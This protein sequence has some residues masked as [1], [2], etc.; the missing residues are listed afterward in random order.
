MYSVGQFTA[1][2][3]SQRHQCS[4]LSLSSQV[5]IKGCFV[6]RSA[7]HRKGQ[8]WGSEGLICFPCSVAEDSDPS[9]VRGLPKVTTLLI[10][11]LYVFRFLGGVRETP[12]AY[13]RLQRA[14]WQVVTGLAGDSPLV[15]P[16]CCA[17]LLSAC[18]RA[19]SPF[20]VNQ[21][22]EHCALHPVGTVTR[23]RPARQEL[24]E[25]L[26]CAPHKD[27]W[28]QPPQGSLSFDLSCP[29]NAGASELRGPFE[30]DRCSRGNKR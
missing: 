5:R 20:P 26:W 17:P 4:H 30:A 15:L 11:G 25:P 22:G 1:G 14:G 12:W 3:R 28:T 21:S 8:S 13:C 6:P 23:R 27:P 19:A 16:V 29:L 2:H 24:E 9:K 7:G 18:L 10:F